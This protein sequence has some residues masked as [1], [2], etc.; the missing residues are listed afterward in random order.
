MKEPRKRPPVVICSSPVLHSFPFPEVK[1]PK[2]GSRRRLTRRS[3]G[4]GS[5]MCGRKKKQN[6]T[7]AEMGQ[8]EAE[9]EWKNGSVSTSSG[10]ERAGC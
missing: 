2:A 7:H 4:R 6:K 1:S 5:R 10:Q 3:Y 9:K 8:R